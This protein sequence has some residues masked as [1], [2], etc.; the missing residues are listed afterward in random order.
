MSETVHFRIVENMEDSTESIYS[1]FKEDYLNQDITVSTIKEKYNL[2]QKQYKKL[3][4]KVYLDTGFK[5][6]NHYGWRKTNKVRKQQGTPQYLRRRITKN[7]KPHFY[8][9]KTT[10]KITSYYGIY[11]DMDTALKVVNRLKEVDWDKSE[12]DNIRMEIEYG[13]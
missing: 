3:L 12:L 13:V 2:G 1:S 6:S 10:D 9:Q 7:G 11:D 8:I 4:D 5:R